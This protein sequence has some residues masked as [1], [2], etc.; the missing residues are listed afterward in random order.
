MSTSS[1]TSAKSLQRTDST[2]HLNVHIVVRLKHNDALKIIS[3]EDLPPALRSGRLNLNQK[4]T[5]RDATRNTIEGLVVYMR[6]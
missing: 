5:I 6:E 2:G 3:R 1:K 4:I